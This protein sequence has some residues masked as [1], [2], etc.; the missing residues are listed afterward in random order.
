MTDAQKTAAD[1]IHDLM[2]EHFDGA[3]LVLQYEGGREDD[4]DVDAVKVDYTSGYAQ[5][6]GLL[7]IGKN[8]LLGN[9]QED[10]I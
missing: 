3:V 1:K 7:V 4:T 5:A 6:V 10:K 8:Y 9:R 2:V